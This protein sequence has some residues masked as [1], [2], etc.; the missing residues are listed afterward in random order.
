MVHDHVLDRVP[1]NISAS[2]VVADINPH[3][4]KAPSANNISMKFR[5]SNH[6]NFK[7]E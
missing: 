5:I 1:T 4:K 7:S 2:K 3:V 6:I